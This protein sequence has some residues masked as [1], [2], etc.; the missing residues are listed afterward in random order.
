MGICIV[1]DRMDCRNLTFRFSSCFQEL[2]KSKDYTSDT[3]ICLYSINLIRVANLLIEI[4]QHSALRIA[5]RYKY[6][7]EQRK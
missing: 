4:C 2:S 5:I 7:F 6:E 3:I 1:D